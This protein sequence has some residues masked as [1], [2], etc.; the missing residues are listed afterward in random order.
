MRLTEAKS[1]FFQTL[2][3]PLSSIFFKTLFF[4]PKMA[5]TRLLRKSDY[6]VSRP[7]L[8]SGANA[9]K[10][11]RAPSRPGKEVRPADTQF[12]GR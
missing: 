8:G 7:P 10:N 5:I 9:H 6:P 11:Q 2:F 12:L 4:Y 3:A 1:S